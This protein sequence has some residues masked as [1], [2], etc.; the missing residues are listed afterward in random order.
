MTPI[1]IGWLLLGVFA[2]VIG[3]IADG[4]YNGHKNAL[5]IICLGL[6][7]LIGVVMEIHDGEME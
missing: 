5:V 4:K 7:S 1:L 2:E 3:C 6:I